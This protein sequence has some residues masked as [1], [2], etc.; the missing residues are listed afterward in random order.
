M[1]GEDI[2]E[3]KCVREK[4]T[5]KDSWTWDESGV[6]IRRQCESWS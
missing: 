3:T 2:P 5:V 6:R 1:R 4:V